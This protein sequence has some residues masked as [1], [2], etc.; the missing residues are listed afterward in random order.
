MELGEFIRKYRKKEKFSV[1]K[2]AE[3]LDVS[4]FRLEKWEKGVHPNYDDG[5]KIK[6]YFGVKDF[7]NFSE[8]FLESFEPSE[9]KKD[10][11]IRMKDLL[12]E[13]KDKRIQALEETVQLLKEAMG[14]YPGGKKVS[15][16]VSNL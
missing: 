8:E 15:K 6:K 10:E 3:M 4:R 5:T 13:E 12:L 16:K 11:L 2:L 1:R 14:K 9:D 7:Q